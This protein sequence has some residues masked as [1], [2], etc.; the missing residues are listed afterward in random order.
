[1]LQ[2]VLSHEI[3]RDNLKIENKNIEHSTH[4]GKTR[5]DIF[6]A[7][8]DLKCLLSELGLQTGHEFPTVQSISS[9]LREISETMK[10]THEKLSDLIRREVNIVLSTVFLK[11]NLTNTLTRA[12]L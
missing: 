2:L 12:D 10:R 4:R 5:H 9:E 6:V 8:E 7:A 11:V 3:G 1:M